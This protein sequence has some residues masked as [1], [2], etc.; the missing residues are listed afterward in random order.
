M[1]NYV[2]EK[3]ANSG[4][5][6]DVYKAKD[7]ETGE[8]VAIKIMSFSKT[9]KEYWKN[10]VEMLKNFQYTRN[11][12]RMYEYGTFLNNESANEYGYIVMELCDGDIMDYPI[13]HKEIP[14]FIIFLISTIYQLHKKGYCINDLKRENIL[15]K[16]TGF[17]LCDFSSCQTNGTLTGHLFGTPHVLAPELIRCHVDKVPYYYDNKIDVWNF[18]CV[19]YEVVTNQPLFG[20]KGKLPPSVMYNNILNKSPDLSDIKDAT[21]KYVISKC[22]MKNPKERC[23]MKDIKKYIKSF[24]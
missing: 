4:G 3:K 17:K 6:S 18:G 24:D 1:S 21:I 5:T 11:I 8:L 15:R 14:K 20:N 12:V 22:L 2:F 13:V 23:E 16:G 10:E 19:L 7:K 9:K